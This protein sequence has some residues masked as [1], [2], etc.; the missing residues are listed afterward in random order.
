MKWEVGES[1]GRRRN[2]VGGGGI[3]WDTGRRGNEVRAGGIKWGLGGS[4]WAEESIKKKRVM[5]W[6]RGDHLRA[7]GTKWGGSTCWE[8]W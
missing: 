4:K 8:V 5:E 6:G 7:R 1:S 3:K 2:E